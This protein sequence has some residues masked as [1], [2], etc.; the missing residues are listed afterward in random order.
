[1][2][3]NQALEDLL[4][5]LANEI[6]NDVD[7]ESNTNIEELLELPKAPTF[8]NGDLLDPESA[9]R[10]RMLQ[11]VGKFAS[12]LT[13]R[14]IRVGLADN[15]D[16]NTPDAPA[17][18]DSDNIWFHPE[19]MG[20]LNEPETVLQVKGLSLHEI[21]HILLTPRTG[22]NLA[23][24]V[25]KA[26]LWRAF[27]ALEDQR[28]EMFMTKR[29]GNVAPW[30]SAAVAKF[31]M[32][33]PEQWTVAFPL[34]HGRKYLPKT[35]RDQVVSKYEQPQNVKEIASLIDRYIVL[36]LADPKNYSIA[37]DIIKRYDELVSELPSNADPSQGSWNQNPGWRRVGDPAGHDHRKEGEWKSS[38]SKPMS[39]AEQQKVSDKVADAVAQENAGQENA[40]GNG[41]G[42]PDSTQEGGGHGVST[43]ASLGDI[44]ETIL[45]DI[46]KS[47]SR[48]I[49]QI[50][51][52][53]SAEVEL[54][55]SGGK[56]PD[57]RDTTNQTVSPSVAQASKSFASELE[58]LKADF[59]PGWVRRTETG[60]LNVQRYVAGDDIDECFDEWDNGREDAVDIEATILLDMSG[61]MQGVAKGAFESMWA[62]KR[63]LDRNGA[64]T[65]VIGFDD[66][67]TIL[68]SSEERAG[69]LMKTSWCTGGTSPKSALTYAKNVL[70]ESKRAI[71]ICIV[72]T[73]GIWGSAEQCDKILKEFRRAGVLTSLAYVTD[74]SGT[75][76]DPNPNKIDTHGCEVAVHIADTS[77]LF[78]LGRNIV[79]LGVA[80]NLVNA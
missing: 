79:N 52:Q 6:S 42:K 56:T 62:I 16:G 76:G 47:K 65:T 18:S 50:M 75:W 14:T 21:A 2:N 41:E 55:G 43:G 46:K 4:N 37:F 24:D 54:T 33:E 31:I 23:K 64:S 15:R 80:R 30:L 36:N 59:D 70:A 69:N 22:S 60:R 72:I 74:P 53:Y 49:A 3:E 40:E 58:R 8:Y 73:D 51:K 7:S 68:Y 45:N 32:E 29:F 27:N 17:W 5:A 9:R 77:D 71:K 67:A 44:A 48:E 10:S 25:Q 78:T 19:H 57:R 34:L 66:Y 11:V 13:L 20:A 61:S 26:S 1:M 28:I 63:A 39:K 12:T 35:L 38:K